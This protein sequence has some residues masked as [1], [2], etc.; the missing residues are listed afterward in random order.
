MHNLYLLAYRM[1]VYNHLHTK[2]NNYC[3]CIGRIACQL[4]GVYCT[5]CTGVHKHWDR[6]EMQLN[7]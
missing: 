6:S 4:A 7:L 3:F 5:Q 1:S 2:A